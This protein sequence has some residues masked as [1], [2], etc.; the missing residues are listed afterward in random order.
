[1]AYKDAKRI[2]LSNYNFKFR[3]ATIHANTGSFSKQYKEAK[4]ILKRF[5][6]I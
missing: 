1:M 5:R 2:N 3:A 4:R 6:R